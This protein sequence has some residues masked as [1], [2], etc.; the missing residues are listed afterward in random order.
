MPHTTTT[1]TLT[2]FILIFIPSKKIT[3]IVVIV[4]APRP[5]KKRGEGLDLKIPF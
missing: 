2:C 4:T 1:A 3:S 5:F